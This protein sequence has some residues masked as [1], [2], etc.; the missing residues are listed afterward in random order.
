MH[1]GH[2]NL[3]QAYSLN[4]NILD[5]S[6]EEKDL[7]VHVDDS[8]KFSRHVSII[9]AKANSVLGRI[10]RAFQNKDKETIKLLYKSMVCPFLEYGLPTSKR[11]SML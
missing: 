8:F 11:T 9:A 2:S 7:G 5:I 3:K 1:F 4:N 10:N 6:N